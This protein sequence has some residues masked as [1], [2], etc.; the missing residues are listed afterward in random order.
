MGS[1]MCI[2]DSVWTT[3]P[4]FGYDIVD[5]DHPANAELLAK[6]PEAI[7][8]PARYYKAAGREAEYREWVRNMRDQRRAFLEG[9]GVDRAIVEAVTREPSIVPVASSGETMVSA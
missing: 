6:V 3:D 5:I 8:Q 1:E 7:L 2:R 9:Y 4:D